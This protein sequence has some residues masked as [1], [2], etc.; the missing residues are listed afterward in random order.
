MTSP[1]EQLP[2]SEEMQ[3]S[4]RLYVATV[5]PILQVLERE[6]G[7]SRGEAMLALEMNSMTNMLQHLIDAA[8]NPQ[9]PG[10]DWLHE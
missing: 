6:V 1:E 8:Q 9:L 5:E 3:E 10:D 2:T 4:W 7:L